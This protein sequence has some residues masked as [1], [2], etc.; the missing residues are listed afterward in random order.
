[1]RLECAS[2]DAAGRKTPATT[3]AS[4]APELRLVAIG[5]SIPYNAPDDCPD[6]VGFV[7]RY[8][9]A[10]EEATGEQVDSLNLS[11]HTNLTLEGLISELDGYRDDLSDADLILV[12]IALT[13]TLRT[14]ATN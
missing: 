13:H 8:A 4:E 10:V 9:D 3:P 11:Q 5:D 7:D 6:C 2:P 12:G 14:R 1:V